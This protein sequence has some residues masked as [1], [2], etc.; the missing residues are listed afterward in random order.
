MYVTFGS[1]LRASSSGHSTIVG[2][3][4]REVKSKAEQDH[5]DKF[6]LKNRFDHALCFEEEAEAKV[7]CAMVEIKFE[8]HKV[9]HRAED[10]LQYFYFEESGCIFIEDED[11]KVNLRYMDRAVSSDIFLCSTMSL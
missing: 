9:I 8:A 6:L 1:Y 3:H 2:F 5:I 7:K 11:G 4:S 10:P